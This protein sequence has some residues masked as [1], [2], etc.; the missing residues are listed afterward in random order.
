MLDVNIY[1]AKSLLGLG[2]IKVIP[3]YPINKEAHFRL[4]HD[5]RVILSDGREIII[6]KDFE[7]DGS[8]SPRFIWWLFPSYG[9]FFFA[10]LLHDYLYSIRYLSEEIGLSLAQKYADDE[11][12]IWSNALNSK[13]YWRLLDN[14][15]RHKAVR[16]F[17]KKQYLD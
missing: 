4:I 13:T 17:G 8:S 3:V 7:F 16:W 9:D 2:L 14:S 12:L 5:L 10:A 15:L 6:P 1:N 11:M